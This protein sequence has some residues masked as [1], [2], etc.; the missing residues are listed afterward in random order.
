MRSEGEKGNGEGKARMKELKVY[1]AC[2]KD[3]NHKRQSN[4]CES[5]LDILTRYCRQKHIQKHTTDPRTYRHWP[6][7]FEFLSRIF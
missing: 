2:K 6:G 7:N 3:L 5:S 4:F 1:V